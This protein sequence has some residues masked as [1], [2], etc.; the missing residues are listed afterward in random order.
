MPNKLKSKLKQREF[1]CVSCNKRVSLP[2]DQ[3]GVQT[4]KNKRVKG[5]VPALRGECKKCGT[6]V[7]KFVKKKDASKLTKKFGKF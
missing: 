1:F 2:A 6:N 7:T 5:G 3:I 4:F